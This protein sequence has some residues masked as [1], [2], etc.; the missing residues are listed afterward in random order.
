MA[1]EKKLIRLNWKKISSALFDSLPLKKLFRPKDTKTCKPWR[2][3]LVIVQVPH[4]KTKTK[5]NTNANPKVTN[6]C[7][8]LNSLRS[9][10]WC[11]S[12]LAI[13]DKVYFYLFFF[14]AS[15]LWIKKSLLNGSRPHNI[16][17]STFLFD[18]FP[19]DGLIKDKLLFWKN[20]YSY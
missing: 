18:V 6:I 7:C 19:T 4:K 12:L 5:T 14:S 11:A 2:R 10:A 1:K 13:L 9:L 17:Y 8:S 20:N 3:V 16:C 15:W